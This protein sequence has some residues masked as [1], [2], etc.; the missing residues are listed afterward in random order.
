LRDHVSFLVAAQEKEAQYIVRSLQG[1]MR[2]GLAEQTAL[3]ALAHAFVLQA[4]PKPDGTPSDAPP[5]LKGEAL[6]ERL[7]EAE[8]IIK[9]V[10]SESKRRPT[11]TSMTTTTPF[12]L[13]SP[14]RWPFRAARE[15]TPRPKRDLRCLTCRLCAGCVRVQ[16]P[17]TS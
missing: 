12:L 2:I 10:Y 9:R 6:A 8:A 4:P 3:V 11:P 15:P 16:C 14:P 5:P 7:D 1:K 17:T 13:P